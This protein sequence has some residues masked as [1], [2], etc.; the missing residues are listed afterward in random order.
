MGVSV[1]CVRVC[2]CIWLCVCMC[3][4]MHMCSNMQKVGNKN[5]KNLEIINPLFA[6]DTYY[7][8]YLVC[9]TGQNHKDTELNQCFFLKRCSY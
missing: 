2:V 9:F 5:D 8:H 4:F 7:F 3:V 6:A 1:V